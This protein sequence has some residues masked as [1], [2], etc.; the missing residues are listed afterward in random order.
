MKK[1]YVIFGLLDITPIKLKVFDHYDEAFGEIA[2]LIYGQNGA[3]SWL[4]RY[5]YFYIQEVFVNT[6]KEKSE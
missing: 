6:K 3:D 4:R 2:R 5:S 1:S